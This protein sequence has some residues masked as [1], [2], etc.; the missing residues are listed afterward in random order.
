MIVVISAVPKFPFG[1]LHF[2]RGVEEAITPLD[3]SRALARHGA[4]DWGELDAEDRRANETA[5]R[6]GTRL[7]SAYTAANGTRFWIITEQDPPETTLLL[8]DEY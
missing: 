8:P 2:T 3:A 6:E 1:Y 4:C 7:L 5:L